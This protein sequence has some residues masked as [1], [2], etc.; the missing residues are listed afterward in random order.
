L[1]PLLL[2]VLEFSNLWMQRLLLSIAATWCP[3]WVWHLLRARL[4]L[5]GCGSHCRS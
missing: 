5:A 2:L 4:Q 3:Q 1:L